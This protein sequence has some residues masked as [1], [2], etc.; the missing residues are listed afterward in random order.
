MPFTRDWDDLSPVFETDDEAY[1][2]FLENLYLYIDE[3]FEES[4]KR[5]DLYSLMMWAT[6]QEDFFKA[7]GDAYEDAMRQTFK[8]NYP[9]YEEEDYDE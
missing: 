1:D 7:F 8:E 6:Q 2:D 3:V 9:E 5:V 4:N